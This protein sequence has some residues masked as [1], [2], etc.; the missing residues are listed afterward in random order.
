[1]N[2]RA[3][4]VP[5]SVVAALAIACG[6]NDAGDSD[7]GTGGTSGT[8]GSAGT[9]GASGT[10]SGKGGS[11][12]SSGSAAG[13]GGSANV[14]EP[15]DVDGATPLEELTDAEKGALCDWGQ[16]LLGGYD[17]VNDCGNQVMLRTYINQGACMMFE[18]PEGCG[19]TA[20]DWIACAA[21][22]APSKG[23][24]FPDVCLPQLEC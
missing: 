10:S 21:A 14:P 22:L 4:V 5:F 18:F 24:E 7:D 8:G 1:M 20:A 15:P 19:L 6:S 11:G 13:S 2:W 23:C 9:A 12:G 16:G 3:G 17:T